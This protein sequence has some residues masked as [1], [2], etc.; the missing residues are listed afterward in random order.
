MSKKFGLLSHTAT[1][2]GAGLLLLGLG[3]PAWAGNKVISVS[4]VA[5]RGDVTTIQ[6]AINSCDPVQD[7]CT[8]NVLENTTL[9][10]PIWIE[11]KA[12][13]TLQGA[14]STGAKPSLTFA[15]SLYTLVANPNAGQQA[16]VPKLFTLSWAD[17][18]G[19]ADPD[20]PA[21]WLMWPFKGSSTCSTPTIGPVGLCSDTTS[22]YSTSGFQHNGMIVIKKSRDISIKNLKLTSNPVIFQNTGIWSGM[23]DIV[24]GTIGV[25]I[26]QSLRVDVEGNE[27]TGFF[28][29][30]YI[31]GRNVGGMFGSANPDDWDVANIVPL[32][33]YGQVGDHNIWRNYLHDN[34]WG[35]YIESSWDKSSRIHHNVSYNNMNK[36]F[37]YKDSLKVA[38]A[39][40]DEMNNQTGG[41]GYLKDAVLATDR[42]YNNTLLRTPII[43]GFG[44]W[45]AG[46]QELVYNN[47][48]RGSTEMDALAAKQIM[49][50]WH[51]LLQ[52]Y[53]P[54]V[55]ANT[56]QMHPGAALTYKAPTNVQIKDST[57]TGVNGAGSTCS[58]G[59]WMTISPTAKV[60][61]VSQMQPQFLWNGWL[62][63]QGVDYVVQATDITWPAT[64]DG[65]AGKSW[66]VHDNNG[67]NAW[68]LV[69]QMFPTTMSAAL[70]GARNNLWAMALPTVL[71]S[72]KPDTSYRQAAPTGPLVGQLAPLWSD[73]SV[74][75]TIRNKAWYNDNVGN[76]DGTPSDRGAFCYD[77]LSG[78]TTFGCQRS[79]P[80]L[81]LVDQQIVS[82]QGTAAKIPVILQQVDG[83]TGAA[84]TG[85]T[86]FKIDSVY[87]YDA[88]PF[89][90]I[91]AKGANPADES[92]LAYVVPSKITTVNWSGTSGGIAS[93]TIPKAVTNDFARFD[94]FLSATD[95]TTGKQISVIGVYFYRKVQYQVVV[96]FCSTSAC[97]DSLTTAR[98]GDQIYMQAYF[99]D[100]TTGL[101]QNGLVVNRI[102][103]TPSGVMRDMTTP[104]GSII[105][106][107]QFLASATGSFGVP[108]EF[109][110]KGTQSVTVAG[111]VGSATSAAGVLGTGSINIRPGLPYAVQFQDPISAQSK[112]CNGDP[113]DTA[114]TLTCN[115]IPGVVAHQGTLTVFDKFAN[116]VDTAATVSVAV[117]GAFTGKITGPVVVNGSVVKV[118]TSQA[119]VS[120]GTG[121][122]DVKTDP[123]GNASFWVIGDPGTAGALLYGA[124]PPTYPWILLTGVVQ[125]T[126][127]AP[128]DS[129][130][131][132]LDPPA[133]HLFWK[134][135]A[136][137]DAY[138][139][140]A[141]PVV[142]ILTKDNSTVDAGNLNGN[143]KVAVYAKTSNYIKAYA[144]A[145]MTIPLDSVQLV[146]GSASFW[147]ASSKPAL[148]DL[149]LAS[150]GTLS[151]TDPG[152]PVSFTAPPVP[153][154]P[155]LKFS[156][157][158]D[159]DCDGKA[160][161]VVVT[162]D[163]AGAVP[164]L[165]ITK[166]KINRIKLSTP[167]GDSVILD[168][169]SFTVAAGGASITIALPATA[170]GKFAAY[171]PSGTVEL[172]ADLVRLPAA[173][174][175]VYMGKVAVVDGIGPRPTK[176][177]I[178]ENDVPGSADTLKVQFSEPVNYSGTAF[179]FHLFPAGMTPEISG[180]GLAVKSATGSGTNSLTFVV[181]GNAGALTAGDILS[182]YTT[183]GITDLAGN[184]GRYSPCV[185][186]TALVILVPVAVPITNAW[187]S[188]VNGDGKADWVTVIFRRAFLK[189]SEVPD[190]FVVTGWGNVPAT[191]LAWSTRDSISPTTFRF[192][193]T[194]FPEGATVGNSADGSG[195]ITLNQGPIRSEA[196]PLVDSVP[197]VAVG[198]AKLSHGLNND[199][200]VVTYS[201]PVQKVPAGAITM[202]KKSATATDDPLVLSSPSTGTVWTYVITPG[203][204]LAGDSI[205]MSITKSSLAAADN[206]QLP[207]GSG[208]APY[209]PVAGGDRAPDSAIV[210]DLNG[211]GTADAVRLVYLKPLIGNPTFTFTWGGVTV[212]VDS[213]G[214]GNKLAGTNG[215]VLTVSG[216]PA[217]VTAGAGQGTSTSL[218]A[219]AA[220]TPLPFNLI[221]GVPPVVN[222]VF[223]TYGQTDGA[224]DTILVKVSETLVL[225]Q[226]GGFLT[227]ERKGVAKP[228]LATD[229]MARVD[230]VGPTTYRIICD[231][232]LDGAASYGLPGFGD[233]AKLAKGVLD[234]QKN[235]VTDTSRWV[236]VLT[237]PYPV[238]Y[239]PGVYPAGGVFVA[240]EVVSPVIQNLPDVTSWI[241][242]VGA[243]SS[244]TWTAVDA[245]T[246]GGLTTI[247]APSAKGGLFGIYITTNSSLDGQVL[248]YD[249]LGIF[250]GKVDLKTDK[251]DLKKRGLV[252]P[253]GKY[254]LVATLHD[255]DDKT[256]HLASGVFM[257]RLISFSVQTVNGNQ[258]RVLIQNKLFKVG[259]KKTLK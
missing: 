187:I 42:I 89:S 234:A 195:I 124:K 6:A 78:K 85:F 194:T 112:K 149:L 13:I 59:C 170:Q 156:A 97:T 242:P 45:R 1:L 231:S 193:I 86:N 216:F 221:D 235:P 57:I 249:N 254:T 10:G 51:Q 211:D 155:T 60:T 123:T 188:D 115:D 185:K 46:S 190:N 175:N 24:A 245:T 181:T 130:F 163:P 4:A 166:V 202:G 198:V 43:I 192:P 230:S 30:M 87:Y 227:I 36:S 129:A 251:E 232:C 26:F 77:T 70:V 199:T 252:G 49:S 208:T 18:S 32:S 48:I 120:T 144:D 204:V 44:G 171:N 256:R 135:P 128:P 258:Q 80:V 142:L 68:G 223:V 247:D 152:L 164:T 34:W 104:P 116:P 191:T 71:D 257:A 219:G 141:V 95:P 182:I 5:G 100:A 41:F 121:Y 179:P 243:D 83:L 173:D 154:T 106:T 38:K 139:L 174:T 11:G 122:I 143:T 133:G 246:N 105:D 55:W 210:L 52:Y 157:F 215:T 113:G 217:G 114:N 76:T 138:I 168:G 218:V 214:Y 180:A 98:A 244:G 125:A 184:E 134:S 148:N 29:A 117:S 137:V 238:R 16:Q 236:P 109:E 250:V 94:V 20:R 140:T 3:S 259:Y 54:T 153:P 28:S 7:V 90:K 17:I 127:H 22:P 61:Y 136:K 119:G 58:G 147:V 213:T 88:F 162:F 237:G 146:N 183:K 67:Y 23:Y 226:V 200:L 50:D 64:A 66:T 161:A 177:T 19:T 150:S 176:A 12:N 224:P 75:A 241:L 25:D 72:I 65:Y 108:V 126:T 107:S 118:G 21:G 151:E 8:I 47:V 99:I 69:S 37:Q 203:Y 33:R 206:G 93:L 196:S 53:G 207:A 110:T 178:V 159:G 40:S 92:K 27:I 169:T 111:L 145:A 82:V 103:L 39:N 63:Q 56:F 248:F 158:A 233:S 212:K 253:D 225:P 62:A 165:D 96:K 132:R 255:N 131:A 102:Y 197:P 79:G 35:F 81:S 220:S 201:E 239:T 101:K 74:D 205:R 14:T 160:D 229:P 172:W 91:P 228:F 240:S 9:N 209:I 167:T 15:S 31:N 2:L 73:A 84:S 222:S 186:D 189:D